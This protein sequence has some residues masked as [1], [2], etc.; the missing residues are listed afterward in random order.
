MTFGII[1]SGSWAIAKILTDKK[2]SINWWIRNTDAI[3]Y[4]KKIVIIQTICVQLNLIL[5]Y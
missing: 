4:I 2:H 3:D 1:G 5:L